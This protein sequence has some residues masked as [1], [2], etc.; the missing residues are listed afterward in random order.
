MSS[1][2]VKHDQEQQWLH[3]VKGTIGAL[4]TYL[5]RENGGIP[6]F[7]KEVVFDPRLKKEVHTMSNGLKY[8]KDDEGKWYVVG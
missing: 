2:F 7:E 4:Q 3:E 1:P 6:V 5:T 8:A